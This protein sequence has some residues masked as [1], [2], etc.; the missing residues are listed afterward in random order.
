MSLAAAGYRAH[1]ASP[2]YRRRLDAAVAC[3]AHGL[4]L[5][6]DPYVAFSAGKDSSVMLHLVRAQRPE[7]PAR[8]LT[9]GETRCLHANLDDVL[10]WWRAR[11]AHIEEICADR[12]FAEGWTGA[13]FHAQRMAGRGDL[14]RLLPGDHDAVFL[15]LRAEESGRRRIAL[16]RRFP[17]TRHATRTITVP[18]RRMLRIAPLAD[19]TVDDVAAYVTVHQ[20]PMLTA[21]EREGFAARTTARLTGDAVR[22]GALILLRDRDPA[23]YNHL[24]ARFPEVAWWG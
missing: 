22:E 5:C 9:S 21:Y 18:G 15:G 12:V 23:A 10:A 11:G 8:L 7:I 2:A 14:R 19:W 1:A 24:L 3:I 4:T 13:S 6:R 16:S 20:L 17:G